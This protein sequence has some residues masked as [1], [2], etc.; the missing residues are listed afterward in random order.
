VVDASLTQRIVARPRTVKRLAPGMAPSSWALRGAQA[1]AVMGPF[2]VCEQA[3]LSLAC[4]WLQSPTLWW[5]SIR[6]GIL[7]EA[8]RLSGLGGMHSVAVT[9]APMEK[10]GS[11]GDSGWPSGFDFALVL[12]HPGGYPVGSTSPSE[13]ANVA[14]QN[15]PVG[16][17][18]APVGAPDACAYQP[19]RVQSV[20]EPVVCRPSRPL[21]PAL[22][23]P[24]GAQW[25]KGVKSGLARQGHP[26]P[27]L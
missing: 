26:L 24:V 15:G 9:F 23:T 21:I 17:R 10:R 18:C 22:G 7:A 13:R 16:V 6:S 2:P 27:V 3:T 11:S 4:G 8:L 19:R 14:R 1:L 20:G 5:D 12:S 25:C